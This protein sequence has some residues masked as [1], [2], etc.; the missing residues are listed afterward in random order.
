MVLAMAVSNN[1]SS[2][3]L[4]LDF[5]LFDLSAVEFGR[6]FPYLMLMKKYK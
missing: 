6:S 2:H 3:G 1:V 4:G 5:D